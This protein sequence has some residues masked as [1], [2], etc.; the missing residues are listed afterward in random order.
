[1]ANW[2]TFTP[3]Q[4]EVLRTNPYVKRVTPYMISFTIAF[5]E[6]Y[7]R[8]YSEEGRRPLEIIESLGFDVETLGEIRAKGVYAHIRDEV[9]AG[10]GFRERGDNYHSIRS[11]GATFGTGVQVSPNQA[12]LRLEHEVTYLRQEMEFIKKNILLDSEAKQK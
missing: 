11:M 9:K 8:Q 1:M 12:I 3:E 6:E 7:W 10:K 5:K 4:I 2:K